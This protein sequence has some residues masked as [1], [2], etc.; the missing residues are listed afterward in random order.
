MFAIYLGCKLI[1]LLIAKKLSSPTISFHSARIYL[2]YGILR[3]HLECHIL[4]V[5]V[6]E[7]SPLEEEEPG[8]SAKGSVQLI[9][10]NET[11][12]FDVNPLAKGKTTIFFLTYSFFALDWHLDY[13][14]DVGAVFWSQA[15]ELL[16]CAYRYE[17]EE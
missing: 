1:L 7:S 17:A 8:N 3:D 15:G 16:V 6:G 14:D 2:M 5:E 4:E 12:C 11:L 10:C 13:V 9:S